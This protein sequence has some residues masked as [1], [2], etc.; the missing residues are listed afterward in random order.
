MSQVAN[1]P[2]D[3][4]TVSIFEEL[5]VSIV[6]EMRVTFSRSAFS[7]VISEGYDFSCVLLSDKGELIAMS[8]D[9]PG[10]SFP[11]MAAA[12]NILHRYNEDIHDG[13]AFFVN[14]P[15]ICGTH[16]NDVALL[17]PRIKV[18]RRALFPAIR[19]HWADI[20]GSSVGSVGG[21]ATNIFMEGL[22]IPPLRLVSKGSMNKECLDLILANVRGRADRQGDLMA[23]LGTCALASERLN[24]LES[25]YGA[26]QV[27][28]IVNVILDRTEARVR[29]AITALP[30]GQFRFENYTDNDGVQQEPQRVAVCL[31]VG[32]DEIH[33]DFTGTSPQAAGPLNGG[34]AMVATA[35]FMTLKSYLDPKAPVNAGCFRPLTLE[36]PKGTF[37]NAEFP[38]AMGGAGDLRRTVESCILGAIA[39]MMPRR[40]CGDTKGAAN[41]C[42]IGGP[43]AEA[44]EMFIYYEYPAGGIGAVE[45]LD[46]DHAIR[47][48]TEGDFNTVLPVESLEKLYPMMVL[49]SG[50]RENSCGDGEW[51]GGLGMERRVQLLSSRSTLTVLTD[52]VIVPPFGVNGGLSAMGN[53]FTVVRGGVELE[54]SPLPGKVTA[55]PLM[56][57]DIVWL[58]SAGG[59]GF[60]D[61]LNRSPALVLEDVL[62][63]Y[64]SSQH[65][66]E[67]YGVVISNGGV[68]D[69]LTRRERNNLR[70]CR[71]QLT[72]RLMATDWFALHRRVC[73]I[74]ASIAE[75]YGVA[76]GQL[77]ELA[78]ANGAPL[79]AWAKISRLPAERLLP[80]GPLGATILS[81]RDNDPV[82][83][84]PIATPYAHPPLHDDG[85]RRDFDDRIDRPAPLVE[86]VT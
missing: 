42:Y 72:I 19:A 5:L 67:K 84:R 34:P 55:F 47:T 27:D 52:R 83:L 50:L 13:D 21:N 24:D 20:G 32:E 22:V 60:G 35:Y 70:A 16:L 68:D 73:P 30:K 3:P 14:D 49:D 76:D 61:P 33:C 81:V 85:N 41:H 79:R 38:A 51:R 78:S 26:E 58:R 64:I 15:Y 71:C 80:I 10:H 43:V 44:G 36:V 65:A 2:I 62:Q 12:K 63:G 86:E 6:R 59:G 1:S 48:Y 23:A 45:G 77:I 4:I 56:H 37:L 69:E 54:P 31:T 46:G 75:L 66:K 39:Q 40:V 53:R 29:K 57:R 11:L 82:F 9:H 8:E 25:K 28:N 74:S 17:R 18:G 7:S